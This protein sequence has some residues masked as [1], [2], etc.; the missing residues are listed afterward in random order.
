VAVRALGA[1]GE[2][3]ERRKRSSNVNRPVEKRCKRR[4]ENDCSI[5]LTT[6]APFGEFLPIA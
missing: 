2:L 1:V 5:Q 3:I 4:N 6:P